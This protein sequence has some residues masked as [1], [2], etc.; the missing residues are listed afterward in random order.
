M[1]LPPL[2]VNKKE[3]DIVSSIKFFGVIFDESLDWNEHLNTIENKVPKNIGILYK[4]KEIIN[5]KALRS[6]YY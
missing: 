6:L 4:A 5:T 3:I 2:F 1:K